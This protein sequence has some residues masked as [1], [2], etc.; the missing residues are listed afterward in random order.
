[1]VKIILYGLT[2]QQ[3][4]DESE[5]ELG[6]TGPTTVRTLLEANQDR[7]GALLEFMQKS[8][9]MVTVNKKVAS[10]DSRIQDG[11]TIKLTHQFNPTYDGARWHNP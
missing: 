5:Y 7:L 10:L 3:S 8:E 6:V 1:M 2:L 9:L 4:L 11:D